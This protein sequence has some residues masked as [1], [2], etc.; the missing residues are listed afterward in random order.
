[1]NY[2]H[3]FRLFDIKPTTSRQIIHNRYKKLAKI[4][5]PD[6]HEDKT[7]DSFKRLQVVY[8]TL[9]DY[10]KSQQTKPIQPITPIT[11]ITPIKQTQTDYNRQC[12]F[13]IPRVSRSNKFVRPNIAVSKT[14]DKK[15]F[16]NN[17]TNE[18]VPK[19]LSK[20]RM[21]GNRH[22][23]STHPRNLIIYD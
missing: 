16:K 14:L 6:R 1:M 20:T 5:H 19:V 22:Y 18:H 8:H 4:Y 23:S 3:C 17:L 12:R 2:E 11:P 15:F 13:G 9:L 21:T 7:G 10:T